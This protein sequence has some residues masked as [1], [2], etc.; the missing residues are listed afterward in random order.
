[1]HAHTHTHTQNWVVDF[2]RCEHL[3]GKEGRMKNAI[4]FNFGKCR[5]QSF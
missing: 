2:E 4:Q 5:I 3:Q 1:M